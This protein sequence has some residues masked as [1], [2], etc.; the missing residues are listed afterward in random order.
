[1]HFLHVSAGLDGPQWGRSPSTRTP[2]KRA[3]G[4]Y[5]ACLL[6][7]GT[8]ESNL[9]QGFWRPPCY[10]YTSPPKAQSIG[11]AGLLCMF[12]M[13]RRPS[14]CVRQCVSRVRPATASRDQGYPRQRSGTNPTATRH[15]PRGR[16]RLR[17]RESGERAGESSPPFGQA[18]VEA[19]EVAFQRERGSREASRSGVKRLACSPTRTFMAV[20]PLTT[21]AGS[22][23]PAMV[24]AIAR[25]IRFTWRPRLRARF[26]MRVFSE[27][28]FAWPP[29]AS[30]GW[31]PVSARGRQSR[32]TPI[33]SSPHSDSGQTPAAP[34]ASRR[35]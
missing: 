35:C 1:M 24:L 11:F 20:P 27:R 31:L 10:R 12:G 8:E 6:E 13:W 16:R 2:R 22:I 4:L 26:S 23:W 34:P 28:R 18:F 32:S 17:R 3:F 14:S 7:R 19:V 33:E 29:Q 5:L 30:T 21:P 15:E 25:W 9:E